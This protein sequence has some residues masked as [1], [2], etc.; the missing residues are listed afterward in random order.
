[1]SGAH[2]YKQETHS[3]T[4]KIFPGGRAPLQALKRR[5][6]R[7]GQKEGEKGFK[8]ELDT[9]SGLKKEK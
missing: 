1:M 5:P 2:A 8:N 3:F 4:Q 7:K 9:I 6:E